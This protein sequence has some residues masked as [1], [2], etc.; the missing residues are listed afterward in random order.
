MDDRLYIKIHHGMPDHPKIEVLSDS[1]FRLLVSLWCWCDRHDTDGKV[2]LPVWERRGSKRARQELIDGHLAHIHPAHVELHDYLEHQRSAEQKQAAKERARAA[3][4]AG[5]KAKAKRTAS[6]SLSEPL[7]NPSNGSVA[8]VE[9]EVEVKDASN[10]A[11]NA[12]V[13][14]IRSATMPGQR[15]LEEHLEALDRPLTR[16]TIKERDVREGLGVLRRSNGR[17]GPAMLPRL[18]DQA[19]GERPKRRTESE[20]MFS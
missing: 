6:K 7:S 1:A 5:G 10:E 9:V 14:P 2:T 15:L 4:S 19:I 20:R 11:P 17:L 3:G 16:D 12:R 18:V 8:E 13:T